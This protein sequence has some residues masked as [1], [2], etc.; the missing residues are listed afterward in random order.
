MACVH[1]TSEKSSDLT[2][3]IPT[4]AVLLD[5]NA[6]TN[7]RVLLPQ[8]ISIRVSKMALWETLSNGLQVQG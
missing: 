3:P 7:L 6:V 8:F 5:R 2:S 1:F 4:V